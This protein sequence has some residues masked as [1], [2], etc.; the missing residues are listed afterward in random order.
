M[1]KRSIGISIIMLL[2]LFLAYS[3][4]GVG[5]TIFILAIIF[6]VQATLFTIKPEFHDKFIEFMNPALYDIYKEK[7]ADFIGK[8]RRINIICYYIL[9]VL[10]IFNSIMQMKISRRLGTQPLFNYKDYLIIAVIMIPLAVVV[11]YVSRFILKKSKTASEDLAWNLILGIGIAAVVIIVT[12]IYFLHF[13]FS[14]I[15]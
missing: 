13:I 11:G 7:G 6:L 8:K 2:V 10:F 4:I 12:G 15:S 5:V 9:S 14:I 3:T 1:S